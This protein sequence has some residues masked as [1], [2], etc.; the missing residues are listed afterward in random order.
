MTEGSK[1]VC[2]G[3]EQSND[4][5]LG[6]Q[7]GKISTFYRKTDQFKLKTGEGQ[8]WPSSRWEAGLGG[9][10]RQ[11]NPQLRQSPRGHGA[12]AVLGGCGEWGRVVA[13]HT[14]K[15]PFPGPC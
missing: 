4:F 9:L 3:S 5:C 1:G 10:S 12:A 11:G 14:V 15:N 7:W 13:H 6:W 8:S 2:G